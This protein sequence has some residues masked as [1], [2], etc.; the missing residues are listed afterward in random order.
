MK[1]LKSNVLIFVL[2]LSLTGTRCQSSNTE[3]LWDTFGVPHIFAKTTEEMYV[4]FAEAQMQNHA[5]LILKLYGQA[6]GRAAEYWGGEYLESDKKIQLFQIPDKAAKVYQEQGKEFKV[7][8]DA[9]VA[10]INRYASR[11][12]DQIE[13]QYLKVLPVTP[14]D[15]IGHTLRV[16]SL[17]FLAAEDI[18]LAGNVLPKGSNAYAIAPSKSESGNAMLVINPHLPWSDFFLWFESHLNSPGFSSYGISLV[19]MPSMTLAFNN[20]LGWAHTVNPIDASDRYEL[21]LQ[22]EGYILDGKVFPFEKKEVSLKVLQS[23]GSYIN[24]K[25]E[26]NYSKHGPIVGQNEK[27]AYAVRVAGLENSEIFQQYHLM[28]SASSFQEF[29]SAL[30]MLQNPMFNVIYAD[31]EGNIFYLFNGNIPVR[32]E[33]DFAFW[34]GTIDGTASKFIW[35]NIHPYEDLPR[36]LNP[37]SGFVQNC[38]DAPWTCTDPP[39]LRSED[40]PPYFS[41]K[42]TFLRPQR[43]VNMVSNKPSISFQDLITTKHNTGMEAADRFLDDLLMAVNN[44]PDSLSLEAANVLRTWDR[45]TETDSKGAVLFA[46]WW[47]RVHA[48]MFAEPWN[49]VEPFKTPKGLREEEKAVE[50]LGKAASEILNRYGSLDVSWGE[51]YRLR[52]NDIDLPA[53]GGPGDYGIFRTLYFAEDKDHKKR[54]IAGETFVAVVEFGEKVHA[55]VL[56]GYGNATQPGNP[57]SGDQL[58]ML[59]EKKLR[60]ALLTKKEI[61]P[62]LEKSEMLYTHGEE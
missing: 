25:I 14:E 17:E 18:Y 8:L 29:E 15:V 5:N 53:N 11:H 2:F 38:N 1:A 41:S 37:P 55:E 10:G 45:Q 7:Y 27:N 22:D 40:F 54:A 16:T 50:L 36:V 62:F 33:G 35:D 13:E 57:H 34:K 4:A 9:F 21:T 26:F 43:A 59:S 58:D 31:R 42:G 39:V 19:G 12:R 60:P 24:Q 28:A 32:T 49:P 48:S 47:D 56:L 61:L 3:T 30:R 52:I 23:D 20:F 51:V 6:R 44:F 46:L